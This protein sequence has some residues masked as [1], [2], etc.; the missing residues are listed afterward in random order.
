MNTLEDL[1]KALKA[2]EAQAVQLKY[3]IADAPL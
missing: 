3:T 2:H 1:K